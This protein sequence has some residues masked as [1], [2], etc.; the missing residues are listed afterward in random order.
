MHA[1]LCNPAHE[2]QEF[3]GEKT[4]MF[5]QIHV[6]L[7]YINVEISTQLLFLRGTISPNSSAVDIK[8]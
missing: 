1:F 5:Y 8:H 7:L 4:L 3:Q 2:N 6:G